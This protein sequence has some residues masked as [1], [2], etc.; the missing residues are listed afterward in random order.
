[1]RV[2]TMPIPTI[3]KD[4]VYNKFQLRDITSGLLADV[5]KVIET[6]DTYKGLGCFAAGVISQINDN[7]DRADI[8]AAVNYMPYKTVEKV[9][10]QALLQNDAD[11]GVEGY[12]EC[13]RCGAAKTSEYNSDPNLDTRDHIS[14]L[15][16]KE[17]DKTGFEYVLNKPVEIKNGDETIEVV[18][19]LEFQYPTLNHCSIALNKVG[20][21]DTVRMQLQVLI[22]AIIKVNGHDA[23]KSWKNNYGS[24]VFDR[25]EKRD[26]L[27]INRLVNEFGYNPNKIKQCLKCKKEF[28]VTLNTANFFVSALQS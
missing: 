4:V 25:L 26:I 20:L 18:S 2:F 23:D 5:Q 7:S 13:P 24:F 21:K 12:Y 10:I 27:E 16:I 28:E 11:D 8:K 1:M 15:A 9:L 14:D 22:E 6:G 17:T 19:K 3:Y